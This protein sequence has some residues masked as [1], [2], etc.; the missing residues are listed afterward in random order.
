MS[1]INPISSLFWLIPFIPIIIFLINR[2]NYKRIKFSSIQYL[3][4]LKSKEINKIKILNIFLLIIRTL[5][6]F[7]IL[8]IVMRPQL[9]NLNVSTNFNDSKIINFIFIDDSFSNKYGILKGKERIDLIDQIFEGICQNYPVDSR[10]KIATLKKGLIFDGFNVDGLKFSNIESANLHFN[11][12]EKLFNQE[13]IDYFKNIHLISNK[14]QIFNTEIRDLMLDNKISHHNCNI[15]YHY[16][17]QSLNNQ[18]I[19]NVK[20]IDNNDGFFYY[21]VILG[22]NNVEN[23]N[24]N[25]S[26]YKNI[27]SYNFNFALD[28]SIPLFSKEIIL[29][30][31][32]DLIDTIKIKLRP[33]H[34]SELLFKI[35]N[36]DMKHNWVDDRYED[37]YYSYIMDMPKKINTTIIYNDID[38]KEYFNTILNSFKVLTNNIDTNFFNFNFYN[39]NS[40]QKY[41]NII[42]N[43]DVLIFLGYN[44]FLDTDKSIIDNFFKKNDSQILLFPTKKDNYKEKYTFHINDSLFM[45]SLYVENISDNYDTVRFNSQ[46]NFKDR[47]IH[48][49]KFK[50]YSYFFHKLNKNTQFRVGEHQ[51]IW[52]RFDYQNGYLD[53]FGFLINDGNNFFTYES[54]FPVPFLYSI[55]IDERINSFKN[56]LILN[57]PFLMEDYYTNQC[58]LVDL[59]NNTISFYSNEHPIISTKNIKAL[60]YKKQFVQLYSFNQKQESFNKEI[61]VDSIKKYMTNNFIDYT[62]LNNMKANLANLLYTSEIT[63]YFIYVLLILLFLEMLLSNVRPPRIK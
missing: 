11:P 13:N 32:S 45:E 7:S 22:N 50:L 55:V 42:S 46:F 6:L 35:E 26:V 43:Q 25:L 58:N 4:N 21:E 51:S 41:S 2:R 9:K 59:D 27:Y 3:N 18:Y 20:L 5:I 44:I 8:F 39:S 37:N 12:V 29:Q 56:N 47:M 19:S 10:V 57:D 15:F 48:G 17:G 16:L 54:I 61:H 1:F 33:N 14:S 52:S 53:F 31:E 36:T 62:D 60:I 30:S 28:Q 38:D 34:F 63:K 23:I 24:L 40:I 49:D